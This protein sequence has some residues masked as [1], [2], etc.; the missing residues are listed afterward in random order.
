[1]RQHELSHGTA[2]DGDVSS[3]TMATRLITAAAAT[4][5]RTLAALSAWAKATRLMCPESARVSM[6]ATQPRQSQASTFQPIRARDS[7]VCTSGQAK[8]ATRPATAQTS[9]RK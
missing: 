5:A 8:Q 9:S 2:G 1:M 4:T 6:T 7:S 3:K